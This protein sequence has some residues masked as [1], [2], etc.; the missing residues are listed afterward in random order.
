V[1]GPGNASG[2]FAFPPARLPASSTPLRR[3]FLFLATPI[4]PPDDEPPA[5]QAFTATA[6]PHLFERNAN[7]VLLDPEDS[8]IEHDATMLGHKLKPLG[9]AA[10][11]LNIDS[12]PMSGDIYD[13][14]ADAHPTGAYLRGVLNSCPFPILGHE[15]PPCGCK[16]LTQEFTEASF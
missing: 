12:S 7:P 1:D 9:D 13:A 3:G 11:I 6:L 16:S 10:R 15:E 5:K 14:T 4:S 8:A 2:H